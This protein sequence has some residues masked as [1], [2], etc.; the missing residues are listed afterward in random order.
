MNC[1]GVAHSGSHS[2]FSEM[3]R[4]VEGGE[5]EKK[6]LLHEYFNYVDRKWGKMWVEK[7]KS[8][9]SSC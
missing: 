5:K 4:E 1:W 2:T 8:L 9:F 3:L 7:Y 6:F